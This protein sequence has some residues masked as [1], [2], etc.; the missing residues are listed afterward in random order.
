MSICISRKDLPVLARLLIRRHP[1][2][3]AE[4]MSGYKPQIP[5]E[6]DL[7]KIRGYYERLSGTKRHFIACMLHLYSPDMLMY[8]QGV[9]KQKKGLATAIGLVLN[10]SQ[11]YISQIIPEI[12]FQYK[13]YGDFKAE[14]DEMVFKLKGRADE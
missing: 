2:I 6:T 5:K 3:A 10:N 13:V 9:A 7:L 1:D 8:P 14:V 12:I 4:L 11:Q